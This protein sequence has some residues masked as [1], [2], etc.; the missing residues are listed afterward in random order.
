MAIASKSAARAILLLILSPQFGLAQDPWAVNEKTAAKAA[1]AADFVHA[2]QLYLENLKLA[3]AYAPKDARRPRSFLD[4]ANLYRAEGKYSEALQNYEQALEIFKRLYGGKASEV[5]DTF[6]GEGEL[7]RSLNDYAHAEPLLINALQIREA[8]SPN[9]P[10]DMAE[11]DADLGEL[12]TLE[13][14]YQEAEPLL[15][16]ALAARQKEPNRPREVA[17]T[18]ETLGLLYQRSGKTKPAEEAF[19]EAVSLF[20]KGVGGNHPDYANALAMQKRAQMLLSN[21]TPSQ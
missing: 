5:A 3:A 20:G 16:A 11:S 10:A 2:E 12:Y 4:L 14:K 19:R 21:R 8:V 1:D 18:L 13:G 17:Q 15:Q 9:D 6:E 7:Y